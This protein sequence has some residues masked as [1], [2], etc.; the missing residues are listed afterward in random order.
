MDR[1][2]LVPVF[3]VRR[4]LQTGITLRQEALH[5]VHC[6]LHTVHCTLNTA[7]CTVCSVQCTLHT[8]IPS[9]SLAFLRGTV[10][11]WVRCRGGWQRLLRG[12]LSPVV[13]QV[14]LLDIL[15]CSDLWCISGHD[16]GDLCCCPLCLCCL[17]QEEPVKAN[18][19][20]DLTQILPRDLDTRA[21][22]HF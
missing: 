2:S 17:P 10:A 16:S 18:C 20:D 19:Q 7:H 21:W 1:G 9:W 3:S 14:S 11:A 4:E 8:T 22:L 5:T 15:Q 12:G 13:T 6:T